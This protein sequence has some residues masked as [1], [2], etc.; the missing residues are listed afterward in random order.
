M[1]GWWVGE[2]VG[3]IFRGRWSDKAGRVKGGSWDSEKQRKDKRVS[4]ATT[5]KKESIE[6]A[7]LEVLARVCVCVVPQLLS[8]ERLACARAV[9]PLH[10]QHTRG[11]EEQGGTGRRR[12]RGARGQ[13]RDIVTSRASRPQQKT[14]PVTLAIFWW[15]TFW[16]F[17]MLL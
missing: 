17:F 6:V 14:D 10:T 7:P 12:I 4:M 9:P 11:R 8:R 1:C 3:E 15:L 2:S 13:G 16:N 5:T